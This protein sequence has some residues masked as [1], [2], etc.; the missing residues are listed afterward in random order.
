[1]AKLGKLTKALSEAS[2]A[3][4][5][6]ARDAARNQLRTGEVKPE[7]TGT[8]SK[9]RLDLGAIGAKSA[10]Q[11]KTLRDKIQQLNRIE[12]KD[13][14]KAQLLENA[15][16]GL[17]KNLPTSV[18]KKVMESLKPDMN[19][20]GVVKKAMMMR[21]GMANGKAHMYAAGGAVMDNLNPGLRALQK[22]RPDVVAKILKK[23]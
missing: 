6:A 7:S 15:I 21:G 11:A 13:S 1:M 12:D 10:G 3:A 4:N 22:K 18:V 16:A 17:K 20:G 19:K 5:R 23:K 9:T 2:A 14:E 8:G